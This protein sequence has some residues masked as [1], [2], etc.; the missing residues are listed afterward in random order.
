MIH[1]PS[2]AAEG[3]EHCK[4]LPGAQLQ[5]KPLPDRTGRQLRQP[6]PASNSICQHSLPCCSQCL[7]LYCSMPSPHHVSTDDVLVALRE[8]DKS[9]VE[10]LWVSL[11]TS[12]HVLLHSPAAAC[13]AP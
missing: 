12:A 8:Q 7:P 13:G 2:A 10:T 1:A 4:R 3:A 6:Q 9:T 5:Q 11:V